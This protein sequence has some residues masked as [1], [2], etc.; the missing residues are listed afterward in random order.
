VAKKPAI[1]SPI[2]LALA[3][4][5]VPALSTH[6]QWPATPPEINVSGSAEVKV[7]PD[8]VDL[9]VSVET[10]SET[11]DD[12]KS[13]NDKRVA[14]ALAFLKQSGVKDKDIQTDYISIEPVYDPNG[15]LDPSTGRPLSSA[16][17]YKSATKPIYYQ[18][19]K[20]IGIKLTDVASFDTVL[21]GLINNGVNYVQGI[22]FRTTE[23]RKYK[24]KARSM[25]IQAAKEKASAM[26]DELGVKVGKPSS[27]SVNDFGG[28]N[29]WSQGSRGYGYG[30]GGGGGFAQNVSQ[31]AGGGA[32]DA[33][34]TFAVGQI[35]ISATVNVTF[36]I[37]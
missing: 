32:G 23:L 34:T 24:D 4:L 22:D 6:A 16:E 29:S 27:I 25:A 5:A 19:R 2:L 20:G 8:E 10:R 31:N 17:R 28:W 11:L 3:L 35:S 18:V 26:A 13:Q 7:A 33:G 9:T 14:Q 21:T 30:G 37:Q 15:Y 1:K 12:A 36:L